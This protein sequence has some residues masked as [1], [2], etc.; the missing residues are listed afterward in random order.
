[1]KTAATKEQI[2]RVV[3]EIK[4]YGLRAEISR[5]TFRT[6]IGL[7]GDETKADFEHLGTLSGVKETRMIETPYK[8]INREYNKAFEKW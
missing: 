8:L 3:E 2:N 1:M 7:V 6:I 5:G 4:K